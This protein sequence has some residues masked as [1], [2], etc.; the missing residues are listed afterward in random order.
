MT[1]LPQPPTP[2][3]ARLG[4]YLSLTALTLLAGCA[5]GNFGEINSTLV[6]DGIHD[7]IGR[8]SACR[9]SEFPLRFSNTLTTNARCAILP[10][11]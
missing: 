7:W 8:S 2:I 4:M 6:T 9:A 5:N 1:I 11:R 10:I 3:A